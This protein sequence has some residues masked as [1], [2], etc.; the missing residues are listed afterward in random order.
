MPFRLD[1]DVLR[2]PV[3]ESRHRL[4]CAAVDPAGRL[5]AGTGAPDFA[6]T[7]RSSAKPFQLLPLVER[8]IADRLGCTQEELAIMAASHT[9]S[10]HHLELVQGLLDRI[11]RTAA[12]L[13]C[14][15]HE[16]ADPE[17]LEDVRHHPEKRSAL[18]NNCS[19]K[20]AG[21]IALAL[22]EGWPV[23]GY[24]R[25]EHPLQ[26]L[27]RRTVAECCAVAPESMAVAVDG[28]SVSVFGLPLSAMAR[29]Y[30]RFAEAMARGGDARAQALGRIGRAMASFPRV[31]EGEGRLAT[32][33]VE[34]SQG[35]VVAKG[36]AE[37][38]LLVADPGRSLGVALKCE[39]GANRAMGPAAVAVL[40][41]L[42]VL[43]GKEVTMLAEH[44]HPVVKNA[45]GLDVGTIVAHVSVAA[46]A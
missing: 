33:I 18:Y 16:P 4:H 35:R 44:H 45:A 15:Y 11:G 39:D 25:P 36:G 7:F 22:A 41:H 26:Q 3:V 40:E 9:G 6:T 23:E 43:T 42:G 14:G 17:S 2:G 34:A 5:V 37:G 19:G 24:H 27:K 12:D 30:A 13:A 31:V 28:C 8:G 38:L 1:V 10:R 46:I 32:A 29:G 20:H 21:M